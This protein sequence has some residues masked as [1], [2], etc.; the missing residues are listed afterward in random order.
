MSEVIHSSMN[1]QVND[2]ELQKALEVS[3][4]THHSEPKGEDPEEFERELQGK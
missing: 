4:E 3:L 2:P 1:E